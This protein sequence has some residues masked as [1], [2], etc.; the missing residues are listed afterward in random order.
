MVTQVLAPLP[1]IFYRR[2]SPD[3]PPFVEEGGSIAAGDTIG[4]I[5]VMKSFYP[6]E[7]EAEGTVTRF[8]V[9]DGDAVDADDPIAEV[10]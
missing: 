2:P 8:M 4:L 3:D 10:E 1:G 6:I 7:A 9:V 5:E